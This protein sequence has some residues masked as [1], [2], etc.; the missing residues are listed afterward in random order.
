[1]N[2]EEEMHEDHYVIEQTSPKWLQTALTTI[3]ATLMSGAL[4][5]IVNGQI[6]LGRDN[7][8]ILTKLDLQQE[9]YEETTT[10]LRLEV[11]TLL[12]NQNR[13]WPRLRTHGENIAILTRE[14]EKLCNCKVELKEPE[15]F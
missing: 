6:N 4:I 3:A 15:R 9:V 11:A 13:I 8:V 2:N 1:M 14:I 12:D 5:W 10:A 7:A